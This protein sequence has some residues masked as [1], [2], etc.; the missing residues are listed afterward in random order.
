[1]R[2]YF[3][4]KPGVSHSHW[5]LRFLR[6]L[7][8]TIGVLCVL[9]LPLAAERLVDPSSATAAGPDSKEKQ[10]APFDRIA[11]LV[12][13]IRSE[14]TVEPRSS[15]AIS[16]SDFGISLHWESRSIA[17]MLPVLLDTSPLRVDIS[18]NI[19]GGLYDVDFSSVPGAGRLPTLRPLI[20]SLCYAAG[21]VLDEAEVEADAWTF[22]CDAAKLPHSTA[23]M[24]S[25]VIDAAGNVRCSRADIRQIARFLEKHHRLIVEPKGAASGMVF[26]LEWPDMPDFSDVSKELGRKYGISIRHERTK[27][28]VFRVKSLPK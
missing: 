15:L 9:S 1:V 5:L 3:A 17:S 4:A 16:R 2:T 26:D 19:A 13:I 6:G 18:Q 8:A 7:G 20:D 11:L 22:R 28:G 21:F 24:S 14:A 27:I 25:I 23:G 12:R 10:G